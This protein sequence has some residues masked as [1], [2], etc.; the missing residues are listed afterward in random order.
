[1]KEIRIS[2]IISILLIATFSIQNTIKP[3]SSIDPFFSL[4][5]FASKRDESRSYIPLLE[6]QLARIAIDVEV[7][8]VDSPEYS[9]LDSV[10]LPGDYDISYWEFENDEII[11]NVTNFYGTNGSL[12]IFGYDTTLD[13][14]E[15]LGTGVNEWYLQ[16]RN[17][18][19][20]PYSSKQ[21]HQFWDWEE[22][23]MSKVCPFKPLFVSQNYSLTWSNLNG[24][25]N[26]AG[27]LQSWG[28]LFW[29]GT[30]KG[31]SNTNEVVI[32]GVPW[33]NLNPLFSNNP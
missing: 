24:Y 12:N 18:I 5:V 17:M 26:S 27:L 4:T 9:F 8:T 28:K 32:G 10:L 11:P 21:I 31:Q 23:L 16:Q 19:M 20:P 6:E 33:D 2:L 29:E 3:V 7:F 22:Y 13:Y 30:H 1:M 25:N 15:T 14:N